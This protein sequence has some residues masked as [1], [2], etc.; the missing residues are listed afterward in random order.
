MS[1]AW[2]RLGGLRAGGERA[3]RDAAERSRSRSWI[4]VDA[5][6]G[7]TRGLGEEREMT[8]R[9]VSGESS[10]VGVMASVRMGS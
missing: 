4:E 7:E 2:D 6:G 5:V 10:L 8:V 1:G 3:R 9:L